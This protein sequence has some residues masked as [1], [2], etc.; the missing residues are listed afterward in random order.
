M[1]SSCHFPSIFATSIALLCCDQ[2]REM[3]GVLY[4]TK[5][6]SV[7]WWKELEL[8]YQRTMAKSS[9]DTYHLLWPWKAYYLWLSFPKCICE[10]KIKSDRSS[11]VPGPEQVLNTPEFSSPLWTEGASEGVSRISNVNFCWDNKSCSIALLGTQLWYCFTF[12]VLLSPQLHYKI[13]WRKGS[14]WMLCIL[15]STQKNV[16]LVM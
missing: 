10:N 3:P 8:W 16:I 12:N 15:H 6:E 9:S 11:M 2:G 1:H 14:Y 7:L 5:G 13:F 4:C